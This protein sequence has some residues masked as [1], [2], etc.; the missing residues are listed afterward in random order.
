MSPVYRLLIV[1]DEPRICEIISMLAKR[2]G[3]VPST[4]SNGKEALEKFDELQPQI[5]LSDL[6]MPEMNGDELLVEIKKRSSL[7]EV[8]MMTAHATVKSAV[9][10]MKSG[11]FDYIMKP[12]DND[13]LQ[14]ILNRAAEHRRMKV[15]NSSMR[16]ELTIKF[17]PDNIIG[18]S[19]AMESVHDMIHRVG[20][21]KATVL[22]LGESGVGKELVARAIHNNSQVADKPFIPLNCAALT[23]TLLESELFGHEKG[24]FTGA[25]RM[26]TGKFEDADGGTIFLDEIGETTM[27]FQTKLLRVLQEGTFSRVGGNDSIKVDVRV[28]AATNKNLEKMVEEG[29]F[30]EDLY[31]RLKVVP[32]EIP[33]LRKR[34][35]DIELLATHFVKKA[36]QD[37]GLNNRSLTTEAIDALKNEDWRGNVREL[38][39]TIERAV[40][41]TR[42]NEIGVDDLW[43]PPSNEKPYS[44]EIDSELTEMP[45]TEFVDEMTKQHV[46]R[47]LDKKSWK[48]QDAAEFL[49]IDRATLYRM[50]KR[51]GI[52]QD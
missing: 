35:E 34:K 21:T 30:R 40:I 28:I 3:Y 23:E 1:D 24:A 26:H 47:A 10:A 19:P 39:N 45:L 22:I 52:E 13:E 9:E 44:L 51:F 32:L 31:Y 25:S 6:K 41:L 48:K 20:P 42:G 49:Q 8:V 29:S 50:I 4:A 12:F 37:N 14:V 5:V 16:A 27:G 43:L 38:E 2:W 18:Q 7:T 15:E 11:A 46:I 36:C 33:P 17:N